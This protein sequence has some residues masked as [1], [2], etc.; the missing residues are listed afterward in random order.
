MTNRVRARES[1]LKEGSTPEQFAAAMIR[2]HHQGGF[3]ASDGFCHFDGKCFEI[4]TNE[5]LADIERRL[6]I[7]EGA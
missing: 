3:C 7:L 6:A 5:R 4:T 2:C 1:W